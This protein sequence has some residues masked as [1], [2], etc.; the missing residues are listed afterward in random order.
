MFIAHAARA[1]RVARTSDLRSGVPVAEW[2]KSA[3]PARAVATD[4][5]V[6]IAEREEGGPRRDWEGS[7]NAYR[8]AA[9]RL[10][11]ECAPILLQNCRNKDTDKRW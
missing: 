4:C 6:T 8:N 7:D 1:A 11:R 5:S 2:K 9:I 10:S 3:V